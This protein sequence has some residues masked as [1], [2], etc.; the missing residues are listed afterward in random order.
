MPP[1]TC[2]D[3]TDDGGNEFSINE[4]IAQNR[5]DNRWPKIETC[6]RAWSRLMALADYSK[7]SSSH[8]QETFE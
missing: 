1:A 3:N 8:R 7:F 6:V 5:F 4:S 2:I